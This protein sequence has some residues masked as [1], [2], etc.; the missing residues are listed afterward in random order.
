[1]D[2]MC[3]LSSIILFLSIGKNNDQASGSLSLEKKP[4]SS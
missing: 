4:Q 1:M 2:T 3:K